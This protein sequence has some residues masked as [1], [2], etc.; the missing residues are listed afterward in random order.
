M[1][2]N[3]EKAREITK[4]YEQE[5]LLRNYEKLS[6]EKKKILINQILNINFEQVKMLFDNIKNNKYIGERKKVE[7]IQKKNK[8]MIYR[9]HK[10]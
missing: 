6:E 7:P 2:E 3:Y 8:D 1:E 10:L 5:H 4:K 9:A